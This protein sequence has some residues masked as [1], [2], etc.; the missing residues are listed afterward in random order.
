VRKIGLFGWI[1]I[2]F[3][4][5]IIIGLFLTPEFAATW[6]KPFGTL[7]VRL[8]KMLIV[9]LVFATLVVGVA[10]IA[11][12]KLGRLAWKTIVLYITLLLPLLSA[13]V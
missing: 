9:P 4:V 2:G 3:A 1:L 5:G 11:P 10:S 13:L 8:L 6:L 12:A 7:F